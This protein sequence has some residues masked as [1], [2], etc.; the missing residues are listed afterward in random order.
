MNNPHNDASSEYEESDS[1]RRPFAGFGK[2]PANL[3]ELPDKLLALLRQSP[4]AEIE[5]NFKNVLNST[6]SKLD[7]VTREEFDIQQAMI[8]KLRV[9][10]E[11]LEAALDGKSNETP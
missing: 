1:S 2:P 5:Q 9:R 4:A 7:L 11:R 10:V 3:A 8:E 6:I